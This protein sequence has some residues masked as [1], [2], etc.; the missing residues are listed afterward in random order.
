[1]SIRGSL[2]VGMAVGVAESPPA[3]VSGSQTARQTPLIGKLNM[4]A[5]LI[6]VSFWALAIAVA[7][8]T[9]PNRQ[10][11]RPRP[12]GLQQLEATQFD[13]YADADAGPE[14]VGSRPREFQRPAAEAVRAHGFRDTKWAF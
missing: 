9:L 11:H 6:Q 14:I 2:N 4:H 7:G 12:I 3:S 1:M 13:P 8:C 10:P 5:R